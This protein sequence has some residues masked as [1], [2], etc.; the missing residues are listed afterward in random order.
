MRKLFILALALMTS[1][2]LAACSAGAA[3]SATSL[4][5]Y[6]PEGAEFVRSEKD[7]GFTEHKYRDT[8]GEYKLI[9]D[10][11]D[12][13]RALEYDAL[14]RSAA[15]SIVLTAEEAFEKLLVLYPEAELI[16]AVEDRDDGR[17]EWDLLV[18]NGVDLAFYELDAATGDIL[19]YELFYGLAD[20]I[21]L[22]AI[23]TANMANA[24]VT[25]ISLDAD[26][27]RLYLEGEA[28]TDNGPM[29]FKI[30]ADSGILVEIE[31]DD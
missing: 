7:D 28:R 30:D 22:N 18:K 31:Y 12:M 8:N 14:A 10:K 21:D 25:E 26:D 9:V 13:V 11:N 27:G 19:D 15:E 17:Y 29:E 3:G 16:A 4:D 23:L 2:V 1:V 20:T 6:L 24:S 5:E